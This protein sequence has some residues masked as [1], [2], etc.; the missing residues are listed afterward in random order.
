M[1]LGSEGSPPNPRPGHVI[2]RARDAV[3][4]A[5]QTKHTNEKKLPYLIFLLVLPPLWESGAATLHDRAGDV[6]EHAR[7]KNKIG[8]STPKFR[9]CA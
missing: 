7:G 8:R 3:S 9:P 2:R 4:S 1:A 6:E 5:T